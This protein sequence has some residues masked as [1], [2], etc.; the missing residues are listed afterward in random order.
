MI[1]YGYYRSSASWRVRIAFAL[2]GLS[3]EQRFRHLRKGEQLEPDYLK[4][5]PQGLV[6]S[7]V[8]ADG[9]ALTQSL[10]IIQYLDEIEPDPPLFSGT[11]VERAKIRAASYV[12]AC[13]THPVQNLKILER[14][15]ILA[16]DEASVAWARQ[17]ISEGL[18]TFAA[19][20]ENETG[21]YAFGEHPSL[22]DICLIPQLANARRFGADT[23]IGRI[24][25][26]ERTC[27]QNAAFAGTRPELQPDAE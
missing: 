7:L 10:A 9:T 23:A 15:R 24:P 26:I 27:M 6:P 21:P 19:L 25:E 22:A 13:E 14:V 20:V 12:I 16:G 17:T 4:I 5:N 11:A 1:L 8:W 18:S 3:C 2:K